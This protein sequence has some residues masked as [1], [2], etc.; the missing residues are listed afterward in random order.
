MFV[1]ISFT[2]EGAQTAFCALKI[3]LVFQK[4]GE[5][6]AAFMSAWK[7]GIHGELCWVCSVNND[8]NH[9]K[10]F[11]FPAALRAWAA[12]SWVTEATG[13]VFSGFMLRYPPQTA[14]DAL[15]PPIEK[16]IL[17]SHLPSLS[18]QKEILYQTCCSS[19]TLKTK[20]TNKI[21]ST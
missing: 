15:A 1:L 20:E 6:S 5:V 3:L 7:Q 17:I 19:Q 21:Y 8:N 4:Q 16:N 12:S 9:C 10:S 11:L 2:Q 14:L 18:E 13:T